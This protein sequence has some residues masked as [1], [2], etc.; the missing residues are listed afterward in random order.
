MKS[1]QGGRNMSFRLKTMPKQQSVLF[2]VQG[3]FDRD[4]GF[5]FWQFCQPEQRR[6][7][8]Y[9]FNLTEV[10]DL[11]REGLDW[12]RAF[13]RWAAESGA[14]VA[15]ITVDAGFKRLC[16]EAGMVVEGPRLGITDMKRPNSDEEP[17]ED[18][19]CSSSTPVSL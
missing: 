1:H 15:V 14:S 12:L 19:L 7:H 8:R 17:S 2:S 3:R 5:A 11:R 10:N 18:S 4:I 13:A 16:A 9:V 6:Y